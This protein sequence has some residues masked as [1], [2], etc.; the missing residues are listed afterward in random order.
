MSRLH[1]GDCASAYATTVGAW[2]DSLLLTA[3]LFLAA[4]F[5]YSGAVKLLAWQAAVTEIGQLDVPLPVIAVTATVVVQLLGGLAIALGW[6]VRAAAA[7]LAAFTVIATLIG[8]PFWGFAG[9]EFQRQLTTALE[10]L[11]IFGG[12][13]LLTVTGPGRLASS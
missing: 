11:A 12:F 10:H 4:V 3:R 2:A 6:R 7:A 13:L 5:L 8:H 9:V 1:A